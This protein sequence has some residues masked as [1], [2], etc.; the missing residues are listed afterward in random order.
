[1]KH[2]NDPVPNVLER[3]PDT[4]LRLASLIERCMAKLPTDRPASMDEVVSE[5]E[6]VRSELAAKDG[7]E[8]TMIVKP[9]A[10]PKRAGGSGPRQAVSGLAGRA[11]RASARRRDRSDPA[12]ERGRRPG[13]GDRQPRSSSRAWPPTTP[14]AATASTTT[15][16]GSPPTAIRPPSGDV[17]VPLAAELVQVRGRARARGRAA[18]RRRSRLT[19][20]TPGFTAEIQAGDSPEGPFETV[21]ESKVV[22]TS[23]TWELD[24]ARRGY[25]VVWI[26]RARS[27]ARTSTRSRPPSTRGERRSWRSSASWIRRSSSSGTGSPRPRTGARRRWSR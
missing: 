19:T 26:T 21:G 22:G 10:A 8:A 20:D 17:E 6:S 23:A 11:R 4:P 3:R 7:G 16:R 12:R 14:T 25:Y 27:A 1:M 2:V 15:R 18:S 13:G 5:L 24:G 9:K